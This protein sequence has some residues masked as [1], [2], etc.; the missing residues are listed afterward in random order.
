MHAYSYRAPSS[1]LLLVASA[2]HQLASQPLQSVR[3]Q[4]VNL[5]L[6]NAIDTVP[7]RDSTCI[8]SGRMAQEIT[9]LSTGRAQLKALHA[10]LVHS[11]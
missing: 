10:I 5:L 6:E 8:G 11:S 4:Y 2:N 3:M 1:A 7:V 9:V